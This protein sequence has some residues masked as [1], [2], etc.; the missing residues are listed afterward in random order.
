M[1]VALGESLGRQPVRELLVWAEQSCRVVVRV[2]GLVVR[3]EPPGGKG[4][5]QPASESS[6]A[7]VPQPERR[8]GI[9]LANPHGWARFVG[10]DLA[11]LAQAGHH[12]NLDIVRN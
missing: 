9:A 5:G 12:V 1:R 10:V 6:G 11:S 8:D 2:L 7:W 3:I 4:P